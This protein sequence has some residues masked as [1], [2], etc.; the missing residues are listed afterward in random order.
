M[1]AVASALHAR[2]TDL[3]RAAPMP[4]PRTSDFAGADAIAHNQVH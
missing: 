4:T 2:T 3:M 1:G